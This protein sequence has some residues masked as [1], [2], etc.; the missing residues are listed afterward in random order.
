MPGKSEEGSH[1]KKQE[2]QAALSNESRGEMQCMLFSAEPSVQPQVT[3]LLS[4]FVLIYIH[5]Q[6]IRGVSS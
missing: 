5:E 1:D 3:T 6:C 4:T 2:P